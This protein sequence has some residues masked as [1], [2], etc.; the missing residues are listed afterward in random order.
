MVKRVTHQV[1]RRN[2]CQRK[3]SVQGREG[4]TW[5]KREKKRIKVTRGRE[6]V[7]NMKG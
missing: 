2:I 6:E 5:W 3:K 4:N 7:G 1:Q